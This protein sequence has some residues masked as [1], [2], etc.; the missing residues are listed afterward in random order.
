MR[1]CVVTLHMQMLRTQQD[2]DESKL[3][4]ALLLTGIDNNSSSQ[5]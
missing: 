1:I 5:G 4:C 3:I 2:G